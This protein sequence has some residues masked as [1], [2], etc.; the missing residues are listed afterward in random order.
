MDSNAIL[1]EYMKC[2]R[3]PV[4]AIQNYFRTFDKTQEGFVPFKLYPRQIEI[5]ES[6]RDNRFNLVTKPRQA[7]VST[8]TAAYLAIN[9]GFADPDNPEKILILANKQKMAFEFLDK[10]RDFVNQLPRWVWGSEYYGSAKAEAKDIYI[11]NSKEE[12]T[13]PNG[14]KVRAVATSKD[15]LRGYT[16]TFLVFDEAAFIDNGAEVFGAAMSS[17]GCLVKDS[18]ILTDNGLVEIDELIGDNRELGFTDLNEPHIVCNM[19]G[20]LSEAT[21]TYVSEYGDTYKI[22]TS[23]GLTLEGSWKHPVLVKNGDTEEW[24]LISSLVEGD[25]VIIQYN[26]NLFSKT[27]QFIP[28]DLVVGS[29]P[30]NIPTNLDDNLNFAY[31]LGLFLAEGNFTSSGIQITNIDPTIESFLVEDHAG[32]G[33]AFTKSGT[34]HYHLSSIELVSWLKAFGMYH[35]G[36]KNKELPLPLLKMSKDVIVNF[37]QGMFDGDGCATKKEVKYSSTS[38]KLIKTLQTLLLN[39]GIKSHLHY[40]EYKTSESSVIKNKN[41]ICKLYDLFMYSDDAKKFFNTI[42]FRFDRKQN[43][44]LLFNNRVS[45]YRFIQGISVDEV[46]DLIKSSGDSIRNKTYLNGFYKSKGNRMS[47]YAAEKLVS[48][49]PNSV[50]V[51]TIKNKLDEYNLKFV[52]TIKIITKGVD[53]T[54]DLHVPKTNSFISNGF[55]SHNTGGKCTLIST[56]NGQDQLYYNTYNKAMTKENDFN[57]V[58]MRWYEDLRNN[59][60]LEWVKGDERIPE[61]NFKLSGYKQMVKDG[62]KPTSSWY[63]T[64]CKALNNDERQIAQELDV[65]FVG[66]GSNVIHDDYIQ[67][68]KEHNVQEPKFIEGDDNEYWI[69]EQPVEEHK[70]ICSVDVARGDGADFSVF[71]IVDFTTM[72]Q[73]VEYKG[74]VQPDILASIVF[75]Y[76][77]LY[78]AYV[79]VDVIGVGATTVF[80]LME[81][82]YK[83]LH[84]DTPSPGLLKNNARLGNHSKNG[85]VPGFNVSGVRANMVAHLEE[86]VREN[87]VAIRSTRIIAEMGT[88]IYNKAGK[89]DHQRGANDDCLMTLAIALWIMEHNFKQLERSASKAKAMLSS[90]VGNTTSV[91]ANYN[92]EH[93]K[94]T[95]NPKTAFNQKKASSGYKKG[96]DASNNMWLFS[97]LK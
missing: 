75:E 92:T 45:K 11:L 73:V 16:P 13:L 19:D 28:N 33:R 22:E 14:C 47:L 68:H 9:I 82:G 34:K 18:L 35:R 55:I 83:K 96:G 81:L 42:G 89:A 6:Y 67:W 41:H 72:E 69:W 21:K 31:L 84:Y 5:I 50:L 77:T 3:D 44:G 57:I 91:S 62:Y 59:K 90:W 78:D 74:K 2:Y 88:F 15:A 4:Y 8:T 66:S 76:A 37:L 54:Y 79:V 27:S 93:Q 24:R 53:D 25:E 48:D 58:E 63:R 97:G 70:Y 29:K 17:I 26:Q 30:I 49:Y 51:V 60:D 95:Y 32:L 86:S 94:N 23:R 85:Q 36:A 7:G 40:S 71:T 20:E 46:K 87:R 38:S 43:F 56:P 64:M 61:T 12:F 10:V 52:D 39:F 80:K 65:S 1:D